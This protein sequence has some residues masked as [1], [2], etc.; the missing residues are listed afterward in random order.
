MTHLSKFLFWYLW[1]FDC[2]KFNFEVSFK[3]FQSFQIL[4]YLN[5]EPNLTIK[6]TNMRDSLIR[7]CKL[8]YLSMKRYKYQCKRA[9]RWNVISHCKAWGQSKMKVKLHLQELQTKEI[10]L[11]RTLKLLLDVLRIINYLFLAKVLYCLMSWPN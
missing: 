6:S 1:S 2:L 11:L 8:Q 3:Y 10:I 4:G 7:E 9:S 5:W